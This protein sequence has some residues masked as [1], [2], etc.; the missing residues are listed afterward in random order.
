MGFNRRTRTGSLDPVRVRT[1]GKKAEEDDPTEARLRA[2]VSKNS[3]YDKYKASLH[4]FFDG[5]KPLPDNLRQML[6]TRPGAAEAL[7]VSAEEVDAVTPVAEEPAAA[8]AKKKPGPKER[9]GERRTRRRVATQTDNLK[10]L[11]TGVKKASSPRE[12]E[13]AVDA[14]LA[15]GHA[16]PA[17]ADVLS[18]A[19]GHSNEDVIEKALS[20]LLSVADEGGIKSPR[21]LRTR[22]ENVAL[23]ASSREVT[24]LCEELKAKLA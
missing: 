8:R 21:L 1:D 3:A 24:S 18:K 23:L 10:E 7:G 19:L 14:L 17:D 15:A 13:A 20:G 11:V 22:I 12:V 16:L 9:Q 5:K 6:L 2:R 4:E